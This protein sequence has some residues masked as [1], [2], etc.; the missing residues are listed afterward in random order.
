MVNHRLRRISC[1]MLFSRINFELIV[2]SWLPHSIKVSTLQYD[3]VLERNAHLVHLVKYIRLTQRDPLPRIKTRH[4]LI[5]NILAKYPHL[6]E[7]DIDITCSLYSIRQWS[8]EIP[9]VQAA[10]R[11]PSPTLRVVYPK[12]TV[13]GSQTEKIDPTLSLSRIV[14]RFWRCTPTYVPPGLRTW[15]F[16]YEMDG[17]HR[18]TYFGL[19]SISCQSKHAISDDEFANFL[20]RHPELKSVRFGLSSEYVLSSRLM[21]LAAASPQEC[22]IS[23]SKIIRFDVRRNDWHPINISVIFKVITLPR[24]ADIMLKLG[25]GLPHLRYL[26]L[27]FEDGVDSVASLDSEMLSGLIADSFPTLRRIV[28]SETLFA[29]ILRD[30]PTASI[31]SFCDSW[32]HGLAHS[33]RTLVRIELGL[34]NGERFRVEISWDTQG[35]LVTQRVEIHGNMSRSHYL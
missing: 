10:N 29:R 11:H 17:W 30:R 14:V 23:C 35:T 21:A 19:Q 8:P 6:E 28:L 20:T 25:R 12:A 34:S 3:D 9:V 26:C 4:Q 15:C 22:A 5:I 27:N 7:L 32:C 2:A 1:P 33:I 18:T 31:P 24:M 16:C 13:Y